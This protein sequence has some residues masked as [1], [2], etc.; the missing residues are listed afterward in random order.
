MTSLILS[1]IIFAVTIG[2]FFFI[3]TPAFRIMMAVAMTLN[4]ANTIVIWID[5][6][7]SLRERRDA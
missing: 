4:I 3:N 7:R 5:L 1:G 6:R 2:S